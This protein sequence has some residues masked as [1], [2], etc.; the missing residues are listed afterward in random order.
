MSLFA[1][2]DLHLH[3]QSELKAPGQLKGRVW[4]DHE[5]K[6]I[7]NCAKVLHEDDTLV[8][9]KICAV[10]LHLFLQQIMGEKDEIDISS[11][12]V[13]KDIYDCR[14][15]ANHIAQVYVK[16]IMEEGE[17]RGDMKLFSLDVPVSDD[18]AKIY[19][20]R[21]KDKDMRLS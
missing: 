18:D 8:T 17:I 13:L 5:E 10:I 1:I 14:I 12:M 7:K 21:C 2:G 9:R 20:S 4:K 11:A 15:C 16:G 6:F 3:F 19:I